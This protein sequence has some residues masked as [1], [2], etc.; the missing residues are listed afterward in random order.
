M[1][2]RDAQ[3]SVNDRRACSLSNGDAFA[4]DTMPGDLSITAKRREQLFAR[5]VV[6]HAA[7]DQVYYVQVAGALDSAPV[8]SYL[9]VTIIGGKPSA[10]TFNASTV[11]VC[12]AA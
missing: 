7:A 3:I 11:K 6:L 10:A 1:A 2:W 12:P 4:Y 5:P 9:S 8:S